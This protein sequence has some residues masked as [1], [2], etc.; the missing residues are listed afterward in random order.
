MTA[1]FATKANPASSVRSLAA[2]DMIAPAT[3]TPTKIVCAPIITGAG[4]RVKII[5]AAAYGKPIV[6]TS[7]GAEGLD[8]HDGQ[9]LL[10]RNDAESFAEACLELLHDTSVCE[11]LGNAARVK[12]IQLYD[13]HNIIKSI[14]KYLKQAM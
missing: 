5:E 6:S 14:Q 8:M 1:K 12:T 2:G 3:N 11:R 9:E 13:K 7:L 4:T 10:L